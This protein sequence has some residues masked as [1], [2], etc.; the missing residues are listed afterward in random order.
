MRM[1]SV[2]GWRHPKTYGIFWSIL[3][4]YLFFAHSGPHGAMLLKDYVVRYDRGWDILCDPYQVQKG[5]WVLKIFRQKGEI[6]HE[7][8]REF[9][10]IFSRLNPHVKD[11]DR[12]R[13]GQIV[14]IPLK[15]LVQGNFPGQSTGV[16]TIPFVMINN[17]REMLEKHTQTYTIKRGDTVS[18]L[19]AKQFGG[20][21]G[22]LTYNQGLKLFQ[23]MNPH[24]N[25]MNRIYAG[26]KIYMPDPSIREK[27]WYANLFDAE[28]NLAQRQEPPQTTTRPAPAASAGVTRTAVP[29]QNSRGPA[30]EAATT[31]GGRL[32]EKG[33][34]F[35]P[36][37]QGQDFELDLSRFPMIDL[38]NGSKVILSTENQVMNV[39]LPL[40]Q[41]YWDNVK[42]V[43]IPENASAGEIFEAVLSSISNGAGT[44]RLA[45]EDGAASIGITAKWIQSGASGDGSVPQHV[46]ITP[47]TSAV[48][49]THAAI[50]RY[51]DQNH[52]IIR[53][54]LTNASATPDNPAADFSMHASPNVVRID[55]SDQRTLV[56]S[57]ARSMAFHYSPN[58]SISFPYAG[59]QVKA[60]SNLFSFGKGREILIDYGD[61]Y[62]DAIK[63]IK[64]TG[65]NIIQIDAKA[66][67]VDILQQ[68]LAA[69]GLAYTRSPVFYGANRSAE[70]N[71]AIT[72][73]GLLIPTSRGANRLF[74]E[75]Q[76]PDLIKYFIQDQGVQLAQI[77]TSAD[78]KTP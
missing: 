27:Q 66:P 70:F 78:S 56:E 3:M 65:L 8:F 9:L 24:V 16:V 47:I 59:I 69:A 39:D 36:M 73:N 5:D 68:L 51:L 44:N 17:P 6:A 60:L 34:F 62:G 7:D 64:K 10:G 15:K 49:R 29:T 33:T 20:R 54:I 42:V 72:I 37:K 30:A 41:E 11:I 12:I 50:V 40:I 13:P 21:Y 53:E 67:S 46:C 28:G 18:Q 74:F 57:F 4:A 23:A 31:M 61:L 35:L 55:G 14:D 1:K 48:Q 76:I 63:A 77:D 19:I 32:L 2:L 38:Q 71:A 58:T 45:F 25:D 22:N 52:I 75:K 26:Q 43:K